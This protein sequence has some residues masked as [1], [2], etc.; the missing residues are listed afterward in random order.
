M[1]TH[2]AFLR[3]INVGGHGVVKM[4]DLNR[5]FESAG[6]KNIKTVIAS[7][8]VA[9]DAAANASA[10]APKI[11]RAVDALLKSKSVIMFRTMRD[12]AEIVAAS[13]FKAFVIGPDLKCCVVFLESAPR[14]KVKIPQPPPASGLE[15]IRI[16]GSEAYVVCR[17]KKDGMFG[18][19]NNYIEDKIGVAAT[20]R[21]WTTVEKIAKLKS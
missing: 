4:N 19:P 11:Q 17:R 8:N 1:P 13:P 20:T 5:A 14:G 10:F 21:T 18:Y 7:G 16:V 6:C 9:F 12:I 15:S 2:V 3:A